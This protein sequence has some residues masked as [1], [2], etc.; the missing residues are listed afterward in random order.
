M[1][2]L[3]LFIRGEILITQQRIAANII[4]FVEVNGI[5]IRYMRLFAV[6]AEYHRIA[7]INQL[8]R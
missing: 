1:F 5:Y 7:M 3:T 8:D 6:H 2:Q 4:P